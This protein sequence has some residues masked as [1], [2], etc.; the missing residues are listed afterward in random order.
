[1]L[2]LIH[3]L[4][5]LASTWVA[6]FKKLEFKSAILLVGLSLAITSAITEIALFPW[7]LFAVVVAFF[8]IPSIRVTYLSK[9]IL[10]FFQ[11]VL[12]PMNQTE[13]DALEAGD[14][15]VDGDLFQGDPNWKKI[16][17]MDKPTLSP[18]EQSFV[19]NEVEELC[20]ML[21]D[22]QIVQ[23]DKDLS[24]EAWAYMRE[25]GFFGMII[26]KKYGGLE[27]SALAH[28]EVVS[29]IATRSAS[30]A[31]T[32]MVPNSLGP[33]ELLLHYGTE[34]QKNHY[35]PR[36]ASGEDVPC[37]ALTGPEAGSDAGA[38]PD[39]GVVC[40]G[41]YKG[42]EV[43]GI[44]LNW[45][46]R[47]ITLAPVATVL[48]LAFKL[49]DPDKLIGDKK[50]I[51]ITVA[52]IPTS[53]PGVEIGNRHIPMSMAFMNGPTHGKDVFIPLDWIVGGQ[54]YAGKGWRMLVECLSAGRAISLP[55]LGTASGKMAYRM[56]GAYAT[57][58]KQFK[59]AIGK[60]EG[61]EE[62]MA[63]IAGNTYMLEASRIMTADAVDQHVKPSVVSAIAKYHMTELA[64]KVINDGMDVHAGRALIMG[65]RNYIAH[66][67]FSNPIAITVEGANILTRNLMIFGQGAVRCHPYIF[68][69]MQAAANPEK[70]AA[71]R[72][73]DSLLSKHIGYGISNFVR[74]VSLAFTGGRLAKAPVSGPTAK[75]YRDLSRLSAGLAVVSDVSMMILGGDLKRR[76]R[77]SA[78][79]G[80]VLSHLYLSTAVLK[81]YEDQGRMSEDLP[82]VHWNLQN[83]LHLATEAFLSFFDNF[84]MSIV[85]GTLKR[86]LFPFGNPYKK[87]SD[88][89]D[90]ELVKSMMGLTDVR[91]RITRSTYIGKTETDPT[92][93]M[94]IGLQKHVAI[95]PIEK[96]LMSAVKKGELTPS[97]NLS[98]LAAQ[99]FEKELITKADLEKVL[100]AE[101]LRLDAIQV[102]DYSKAY[103][104]G[105]S[106]GKDDSSEKAA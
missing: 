20:D 42:K 70:A 32:V 86:L 97:T 24:E 47:Y 56:T 87:P 52:L 83:N 35:L 100:D 14:V 81:Y 84:G 101:K 53:H 51:G 62:A 33:A 104:A 64:R 72:Q 21:D 80:D 96:Q 15:W 68:K 78:R 89:L 57:L 105:L 19:D 1:M 88:K 39:T 30:A 75:Y 76:E 95:Q 98:E 34:D 90:R 3:M 36:L 5:L 92:G 65:E 4:V 73:F 63:R 59:L 93:R 60:F 85:G 94:E 6:A 13:K 74:A 103:V 99:A 38:I 41:E 79:L 82:Y 69:E 45:N 50:D 2:T 25:K 40:K 28:S 49:S 54:E 91:E 31:V 23:H 8:G 61:V 71:L 12:P 77:L 106:L 29:K 17:H 102:D 46:K 10:A 16:L 26:P 9:P 11:R 7:V 27:F 48:G 44:R 67:Y 43:L 66:A 55:A 37:F 22:W 58:R 18:R